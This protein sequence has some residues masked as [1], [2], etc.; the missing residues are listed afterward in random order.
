MEL[1]KKPHVSLFVG[2]CGSGKSQLMRS[3]LYDYQKAGVF[4]FILCYCP[5]KFNGD[6]DGILPKEYIRDDYSDENFMK[7]IKKLKKW[8]ENNPEKEL[9]QSLII[10]SDMMSK[11]NWY[12]PE[13]SN[14]AISHR[15]YKLT[16]WMDCQYLQTAS[17][18]TVLREISNY[19][20]L[21]NTKYINSLK[22]YHMAFGNLF[23]DFKEFCAYFQQLTKEKYTC[24][25]YDAS[26]EEKEDNYWS[27]RAPADV[28]KFSLKYKI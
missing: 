25:V 20:F 27:F 6:W 28:P 11:I 8:K 2:R 23:D 12:S 9:P 1:T 22:G 24:M 26:K 19:A 3:M 7:H 17:T 4:K 10:M 14:V 13:I 15:H 5:T 21:F 18:N 16:F